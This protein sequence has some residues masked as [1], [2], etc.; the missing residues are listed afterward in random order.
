MDA[1]VCQ[2]TAS[3]KILST[4]KVIDSTLYAEGDVRCSA[5]EIPFINCMFYAKRI[6]DCPSVQQIG[7][8]IRITQGSVKNNS[9]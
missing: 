7:D 1:T 5:N 3:G 6:E 2:K 9:T 8:V 4:V